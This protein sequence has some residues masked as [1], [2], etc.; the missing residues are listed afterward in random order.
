[1]LKAIISVSAL[2]VLLSAC[3]NEPQHEAIKLEKATLSAKDLPTPENEATVENTLKTTEILCDTVFKSKGYKIT[4]TNFNIGNEYETEYNTSFLLSKSVNGH[5]K[6]IFSDSIYSGVQEVKFEDFN[7]DS[8]KD[9]LIQNYSDV[10][11]NWTYHLYL[12]DTTRDELKKI[13][14]FEEIKNPNYLPT[15][16]LIDNLVMSG[17]NWTSFYKIQGDKIK[18]FGL[19]I[20]EEEDE[21]AYEREYSKAIETILKKKKSNQ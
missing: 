17:R 13:K 10:R 9:I 3:K 19:I 21:N 6:P 5:F 8:V 11:S 14:G 1:M 2:L 18:D 12:V 16:N 4:L 15:Y 7:N 20:Y